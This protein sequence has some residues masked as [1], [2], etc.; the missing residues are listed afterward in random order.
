VIEERLFDLVLE[1]GQVIFIDNFKAVHGRRPF[2]AHYDG[3]DRWLKRVNLTRDL[4]KSRELR[5]TA[6][7][8]VVF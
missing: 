2:K 1:A 4:R 7:S 8:R 6:D 3:T 5:E